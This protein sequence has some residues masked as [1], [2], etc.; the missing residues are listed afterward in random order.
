MGLQ[1]HERWRYQQ[2][3]RDHI[4]EN[5]RFDASVF[6][7]NGGDDIDEFATKKERPDYLLLCLSIVDWKSQGH[8]YQSFERAIIRQWAKAL[9]L[10]S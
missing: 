3:L 10:I 2:K 5:Q 4:R 6:P 1:K 8:L 9:L 7:Q